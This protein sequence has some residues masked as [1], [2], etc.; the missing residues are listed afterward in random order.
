M[1]DTILSLRLQLRWQYLESKSL[2]FQPLNFNVDYKFF[3]VK[4]KRRE[5]IDRSGWHM[6]KKRDSMLSFGLHFASK[7]L[8]FSSPSMAFQWKL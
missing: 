6:S 3:K 4:I 7:T 5:M 2:R 8:Q 1:R